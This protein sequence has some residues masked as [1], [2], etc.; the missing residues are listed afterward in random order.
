MAY[1]EDLRIRLIRAVEK[2][3]SARS[4]GQ[5]FEVSASTAVKWMQAFRREGR[6]APKPHGGGRRSPLDAHEAWLRTRIEE[7]RMLGS[8]SYA[9]SFQSAGLQS[10]RARFHAFFSGLAIASKKACWP[11]NRKGPTSRR[12]EKC[13]KR[14]S[15][16]SIRESWSLSMKQGAPRT[17]FACEAGRRAGS[18]CGGAFRTAIG[19]SRLLQPDCALTD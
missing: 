9:L 19:K 6:P 8:L 1:S 11:A 5:V 7:R 2:G 12:R 18:D 13:G 4:Q 16:I 3:G 14:R 10:A 17:W 15:P